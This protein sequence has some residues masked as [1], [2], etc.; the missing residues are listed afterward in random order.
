MVK[1]SKGQLIQYVPSHGGVHTGKPQNQGRILDPIIDTSN[2]FTG[3][4]VVYIPYL[5]DL[6][7]Y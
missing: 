5:S 6:M 3:A 1:F 2:T 4:Y 7:S